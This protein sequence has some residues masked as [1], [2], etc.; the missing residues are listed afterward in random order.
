MKQQKIEINQN[1]KVKYIRVVADTSKNNKNNSMNIYNKMYTQIKIKTQNRTSFSKLILRVIKKIKIV[2]Y[3]RWLLHMMAYSDFYT[4][5]FFYV[6]PSTTFPLSLSGNLDL[7]GTWESF[8]LLLLE[9]RRYR[10]S[11]YRK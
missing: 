7:R 10:P 6:E 3:W 2:S 1:R 4:W 8:K 11:D 5:R 9:R